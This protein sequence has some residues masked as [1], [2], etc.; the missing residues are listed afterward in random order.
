MKHYQ[1]PLVVGSV[2]E[3]DRIAGLASCWKLEMMDIML[4]CGNL[5]T[6]ICLAC[7]GWG[8]YRL[9]SHCRCPRTGQSDGS[10]GSD[11]CRVLVSH[12]AVRTATQTEEEKACIRTF[13]PFTQ[14]IT[15]SLDPSLGVSYF[16]TQPPAMTHPTLTPHGW[17]W[18]AMLERG[19]APLPPAPGRHKTP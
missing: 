7:A 5:V 6:G 9:V 2:G 8:V 11:E 13:L 1:T 18:C 15:A 12:L 3:A 17:W 16:P 10:R 19:A 4:C 14:L